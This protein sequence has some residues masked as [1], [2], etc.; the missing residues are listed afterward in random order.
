M[1]STST[2]GTAVSATA[3]Y[4]VTACALWFLAHRFVR[5]MSKK[6]AIIMLLLPLCFTGRA[7]LTGRVYAPIDFPYV[8]QPLLS[9]RGDFGV[10]G[11]H[12]GIL[13]DVY[14]LNI[15]W[16]YAARLSI[17]RGEW[18]LWNPYVAAGDILAAAAQPTPYEPISLVSLLLPMPVSLTFL[19][20]ITFF[21]GALL[22]FLFL[23]EI[24]CSRED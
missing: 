14:S 22:M 23:R 18:P 10:T 11:L 20:A 13:S 5:T 4:L 12:N 3:L 8:A 21:L 17:L 19:A 2:I 24:A 7:L 9:F 16:K 6:A 15:P 1:T